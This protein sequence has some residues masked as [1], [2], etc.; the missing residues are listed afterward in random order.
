MKFESGRNIWRVARAERAAVLIDGA[1]YFAAIRSAMINARQSILIA[2]WDIHS[3]TRL[4]GPSGMADDGYPETFAEFL[5]ALVHKRPELDI[6]L[7]L[8]DFSM[9]YA[10]ERDLFPTMTLRWNT[11]HNI[12]FCL[13]D[14][15]P[16]GSSQHQKLVVIDDAVGFSGGLDITA[17]RWDTNAH[18]ANDP[19]RF[20]PAGVPYE[21]FHDVQ[22]L[23]DGEAA[24]ALGDL[25]RARWACAAC[26]DGP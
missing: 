6:R 23:V 7:L 20:D 9:L 10:A 13:D 19:L 17:R 5:V 26:E 24:R 1:N 12:R 18:R 2:G 25:L 16:I 15:V 21:P 4:V 3:Q 8:W 14:C 11:P 22:M